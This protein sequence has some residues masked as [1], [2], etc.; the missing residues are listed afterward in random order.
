[1]ST[2]QTALAECPSCFGRFR[3]D[4]QWMGRVIPCPHCREL[5]ELPAPTS[6]ATASVSTAGPPIPTPP[7]VTQTKPPTTTVVPWRIAGW[8]V[9]LGISLLCGGLGLAIS[10][11]G[12]RPVVDGTVE[13]RPR[14]LTRDDFADEFFE[15]GLITTYAQPRLIPEGTTYP[16]QGDVQ[17][18][19]KKA[20]IHA[21]E[22]TANDSRWSKAFDAVDGSGF[23]GHFTFV[24]EHYDPIVVIGPSLAEDG[25]WECRVSNVKVQDQ[26]DRPPY[27]APVHLCFAFSTDLQ[28][29]IV[30]RVQLSSGVLYSKPRAAARNNA[31]RWMEQ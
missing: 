20:V 8:A 17:L 19:I 23:S 6:T 16:S 18:A 3:Y 5:T 25:L 21:Y 11:L 10:Y 22:L 29:V 31:E 13:G 28:T 26:E 9:I 15:I 30:D 12:N 1:M 7:I 24:N 4:M 14:P 27:P 2:T